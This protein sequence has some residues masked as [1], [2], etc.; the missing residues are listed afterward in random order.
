[1][2]GKG[3]YCYQT[4]RKPPL[5]SVAHVREQQPCGAL[6]SQGPPLGMQ[7]L[8]P[9][10]QLVAQTSPTPRQQSTPIVHG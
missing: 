2:Q 7:Q 9:R 1:M 3:V 5:L 4:H 6:K 8:L 10:Y